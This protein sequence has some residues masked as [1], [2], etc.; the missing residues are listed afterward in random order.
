MTMDPPKVQNKSWPWQHYFCKNKQ[1]TA[2]EML[3][4]PAF[5]WTFSGSI[6]IKWLSYIPSLR[7]GGMH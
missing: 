2:K 4:G 7:F 3:L 1:K 5:F 6:A